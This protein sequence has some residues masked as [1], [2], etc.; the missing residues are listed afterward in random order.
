M[1]SEESEEK[2]R[3]TPGKIRPNQIITTFGPGSLVQ[4]EYDSVLVMG[5][6]FWKARSMYVKKN[7]MYLEK[8]TKKDHFKMPRHDKSTGQTIGCI[9]FPK[10][11]V[12]KICKWLQPH[13][14]FTNDK[15]GFH[16]KNHQKFGELLP[17]RLVVV[18]KQGHLD[19]FPWIKW[20]HS[21]EKTPVPVCKNP[22]LLWIGGTYSSSLSS[23]KIK[24][25]SCGA[26][27]SLANATDRDEGIKLYNSDEDDFYTLPCSGQLPWLKQEEDCKKINNDGTKDN[28]KTETAFGIISRASS[29]YYSKVIR[30]IIVPELA[31]P[32]V[33]YLQTDDCKIKIASYREVDENISDSKI[34]ELILKSNKD[35]QIRQYTKEK[36]LDFRN[37][38]LKRESGYKLETELDLKKIEYA[39]LQKNESEHD[40]DE[41]EIDEEIVI[42]DVLL[43]DSHKNVFEIIK[44]LPILTALEVSRYFTRLS[45]PGE[46]SQV[47]DNRKHEI[48]KVQITNGKTK[49][50][51]PIKTKNWLPCVVKKGEGIFM[52][53][54]EDFI[55]KCLNDKTIERL[56]AMIEN[57]KDWEDVTKWPSSN[58]VDSQFILLHSISHLLIKELS[59]ASG[60]N[61]A[62]ISERIYSSENMRGL[63][64]YTTSSGDGS[65]GGLVKQ[66]DLIQIIN[67]ALKKKKICSR[68]PICIS[69]DPKR[70]KEKNLQL[71]LRQ[72]GSACFGCMML[73][74]TSCENFNKML[75]RKILVDENFGMV[76]EIHHD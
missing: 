34:A 49:Y 21:N 31:H 25:D 19:E 12:C 16:C 73:P 53:F 58:E 54:N 4:T 64:I 14:Q 43:D 5:I 62:S 23:Y 47:S 13:K 61:E 74:E 45:P 68:D 20:A 70:M 1:M 56:D 29:L 8:I 10:W 41:T 51:Q 65:L 28:T 37:A 60:Y 72:N 71:H 24:C 26:I 66:I 63:L 50:G 35:F 11:G 6:D 38:L 59:L 36:V 39:D 2:Y 18:C 48:C 57:H 30:G 75:D 52:V 32:I 22:K 42:K 55:K 3:P 33:K 67:N 40:L 44:Q 17:A 9:S 15:E 69:E 7:H 27:N 76:R 46:I